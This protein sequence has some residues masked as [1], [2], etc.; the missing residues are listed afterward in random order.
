MMFGIGDF[1]VQII[2]VDCQQNGIQHPGG[3]LLHLLNIVTV[4]RH[5]HQIGLLLQGR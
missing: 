5:D 2:L 1:A 3:T 4:A